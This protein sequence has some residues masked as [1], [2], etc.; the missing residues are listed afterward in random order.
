MSVYIR[1]RLWQR[2]HNVTGPRYSLLYAR[3]SRSPAAR[4]TATPWRLWIWDEIVSAWHLRAQFAS[5]S[6]AMAGCTASRRDTDYVVTDHVVTRE[7][8]EA[9]LWVSG[10]GKG[11]RSAWR[12]PPATFGQEL[13][14]QMHVALVADIRRRL[15]AERSQS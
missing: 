7:G 9:D 5:H 13:R 14:R 4:W 6:D 12:G 8:T 11:H 10:P 2:R 15:A 1:W 3:L